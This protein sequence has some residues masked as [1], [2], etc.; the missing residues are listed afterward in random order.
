VIERLTEAHGGRD[1]CCV[2]HGGTIRAAVA[3]ALGLDPEI[4]LRVSTVNLGITR[5]DHIAETG[6]EPSW[7]VGWINLAPK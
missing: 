6:R 4:A 1:I 7:R 2:A 3:H 5:L